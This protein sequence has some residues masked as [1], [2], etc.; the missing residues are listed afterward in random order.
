MSEKTLYEY[1]GVSKTANEDEIKK[2]FR[3]LSMQYHPDRK[4]GNDKIY[5]EINNA[6]NVLSDPQKREEY[7]REQ[8]MPKGFGGMGGVGHNFGMHSDIFNMM[9]GGMGGGMGGFGP[10]VRVYQNGRPVNTNNMTPSPLQIGISVTL[11]DAFLGSSRKVPINRIVNENGRKRQETELMEIEIPRGVMHNETVILQKKGHVMSNVNKGDL[12]LIFQI[13]N[14]AMFRRNNNDLYYRHKITFKESLCGFQFQIKHLDGKLYNINNQGGT[15]IH[16]DVK[17]VVSNLGMVRDET[18]GN[19]I[20][21]FD[22]D[23]PNML[24]EDVIEKLK[25][26][27]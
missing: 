6:Y 7:D 9:F 27:L 2:S 16:K 22:I 5:K 4:G 3:K 24:S 15:I 19:L 21:E 1:L 25:E 14:D 23:Y 18:K 13:K 12:H 10:N 11:K 20:I 17:K 8:S 26:I